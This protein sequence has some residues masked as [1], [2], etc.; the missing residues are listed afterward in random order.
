M[1]GTF[2]IIYFN[3]RRAVSRE[4]R[5]KSIIIK[6]IVRKR[7]IKKKKNKKPAVNP[8][9]RK[10]LIIK[11]RGVAYRRHATRCPRSSR[12]IFKSHYSTWWFHFITFA[13]FWSTRL[14]HRNRSF[15]RRQ[16]RQISVGQS[17]N[18]FIINFGKSYLILAVTRKFVLR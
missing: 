10:T 9:D 6:I 15:V 11:F 1:Y 17:E 13:S 4:D 14:L 12:E 16:S 3:H 7:V 2:I 5:I 8:M 18:D